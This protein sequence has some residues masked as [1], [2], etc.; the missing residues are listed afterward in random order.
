M[1]SSAE[2]HTSTSNQ[3]GE[4][5]T[6]ASFAPPSK[7]RGTDSAAP[8]EV[9]VWSVSLVR[10]VPWCAFVIALLVW[11]AAL[12]GLLIQAFDGW[13]KHRGSGYYNTVF[14]DY[15]NLWDGGAAELCM[16][17]YLF[18]EVVAWCSVAA[19][20]AIVLRW[21]AATAVRFWL[22]W[23]VAV[24]ICSAAISWLFY[25]LGSTWLVDE[26]MLGTRLIW[27]GAIISF[28][29]VVAAITTWQLAHQFF[30]RRTNSFPKSLR[31]PT[32][33]SKPINELW[34]ALLCV[35]ALVWLGGRNLVSVSLLEVPMMESEDSK[36]VLVAQFILIPVGVLFLAILELVISELG[37]RLFT[38][39]RRQIIGSILFLT[40]LGGCGVLLVD[41]GALGI[42]TRG[43]M[44][45]WLLFGMLMSGLSLLLAIPF[46]FWSLLHL[47]VGGGTVWQRKRLARAKNQPPN[48]YI[49][50]IGYLEL[51]AVILFSFIA[52]TELPV[53]RK[54]LDVAWTVKDPDPRKM[55][56]LGL[57][58]TSSQRVCVLE[59]IQQLSTE[60]IN[61]V[62]PETIHELVSLG[63]Q[64]FQNNELPKFERRAWVKFLL[65][66]D[67]DP[68]LLIVSWTTDPV[69]SM[70]T[71]TDIEYLL[72]ESPAANAFWPHYH[73]LRNST[74]FAEHLYALSVW[75]ESVSRDTRAPELARYQ[76]R[77]FDSPLLPM[78]CEILARSE[79]EDEILELLETL[80]LKEDG[81]RAAAR[82][83]ASYLRAGRFMQRFP[84]IRAVVEFSI[85]EPKS[86]YLANLLESE[87]ITW[88][89]LTSVKPDLVKRL[90]ET[91][92]DPTFDEQQ[93]GRLVVA[94]HL[95][96]KDLQ[97]FSPKTPYEK[98]LFDM[99]IWLLQVYVED[100][101]Q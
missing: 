50:P 69:G 72:M 82:L 11:L 39:T 8:I 10:F 81:L 67:P 34:A 9:N 52:L 40:L 54:P 28:V 24:A 19:I 88:S 86:L 73:E 53:F 25:S 71:R 100:E 92:V 91:L 47:A 48:E 89:D 5:W 4:T 46:A 35:L 79:T 61:S 27:T 3:F 80:P 85:Q 74:H 15:L 45:G 62:T 30:L 57:L 77:N 63:R 44:N 43:D 98:Q 83:G 12:P 70:V 97:K 93:I 6:A 99:S 75:L 16:G 17:W 37:L 90:A 36:G 56:T 95:K 68:S 84:A 32:T 2:S 41:L 59:T 18:M 94:G 20:I 60:E 101:L 76:L 29:C 14:Y 21:S 51:I 96:I 87:T 23:I 1:S 26:Q 38:K 55:L 78:E 33:R 13:G 22:R 58:G 49:V 64:E 65:D 7:D 42:V 31:V 66:H